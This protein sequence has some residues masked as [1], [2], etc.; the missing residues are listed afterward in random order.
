MY[1]LF[2]KLS[3]YVSPRAIS[4]S[5][6]L[7]IYVSISLYLSI[8]L[9]IYLSVCLSVCLSIYPSIY[10]AGVNLYQVDTATGFPNTYPLG[11]DLSVG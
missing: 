5:I 8:Y 6:Y 3:I 10:L 11:S 9:L 2:I 7:P 1:W 4:L